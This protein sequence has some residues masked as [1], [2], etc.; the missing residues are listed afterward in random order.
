MAFNGF[1]S[2]GGTEIANAERVMAYARELIPGPEWGDCNDCEDLHLAL[3]DRPYTSPFVDMP[4]WYSARNQDSWDFCGFY[5]LEIEGL[6]DGVREATVT[7]LAIDGGVVSAPR[8]RSREIKVTGLLIAATDAALS[9]GLAWLTTALEGAPCRADS[10]CT[11]DHLCFYS[12]CPPM[13]EDSP[14]LPEDLNDPDRPP[15]SVL[16]P[17]WLCDTGPITEW[18][19]AC[20]APYERTLYQV[21]TTS[22]PSVVERY[23]MGCG[24]MIRVEFTM[25]AGVPWAYSTPIA[26]CPTSTTPIPEPIT[27]PEVPCVLVP[28]TTIVDPDCPVVPPPPR[29]PVIDISCVDTPDTWLRYEVPMPNILLPDFRDTVPIINLTTGGE[30]VRQVRVRFYPNPFMFPVDQLDACNF[31][32]EFVVTYIPAN[33]T[34]TID[35]IRQWVSVA[36]PGGSIATANHLLS[37]SSGGPVEWPLLG[38]G[39]GYSM[40][41]DVSPTTA[42][43]ITPQ[44]CLAART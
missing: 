5:P 7:E 23:N 1:L 16:D 3:G 14:N 27:V 11:G 25:V 24:F 17:F 2:L 43:E 34:M 15:G 20:S 32:G 4:E 40:V 44:I 31:C 33:S 21:T 26:A 6:D 9:Y 10:S 29:P 41:V 35:G 28:D 30:D 13:C 38:C 36:M 12:S 37:S 18:T 19:R 22:G 8:H 42:T 39:T